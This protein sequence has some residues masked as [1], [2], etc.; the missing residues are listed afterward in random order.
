[1]SAFTIGNACNIP[2]NLQQGTIPNVQGALF[3]WFQ[4]LTFGQLT[5]TTVDFQVV[6]T[7]VNIAFWGVVVPMGGRELILKP[8]GQRQWNWSSVY[9]QAAPGGAI[10]ALKADDIIIFL[11]T[12]YRVMTRKEHALYGFVVY[13]IVE[14]YIGSVPTP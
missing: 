14:D 9:A 12:Q 2:L 13:E 5:K 4:D 7:V 3:D 10:M 6:E 8:E 11:G 1:M